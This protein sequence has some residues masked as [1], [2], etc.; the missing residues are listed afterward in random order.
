[1]R[2]KS[3]EN[4][5]TR[6]ARIIAYRLVGLQALVVVII[7]LCWSMEGA[8]SIW[9]TLLGGVACVLPSFC[10]A[11]RFF[12]TTSARSSKKIISTFYVGE[13]IKLAFSAVLV[14]LIILFIPVA[15]VPFITG[16]IG[17]QLGFWLAPVLTKLGGINIE[18][19]KE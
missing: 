5:A 3:A 11:R 8:T 14:L 1:M 13:V 17:A 7:A 19:V 16:F 10:F 18:T 12:A 15:I 4:L 6:S 9:S 2:E